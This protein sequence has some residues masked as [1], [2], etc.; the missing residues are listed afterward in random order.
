MQSGSI[1]AT[2]EAIEKVLTENGY[3]IEKTVAEA[4]PELVEPKREDFKSDE[5]FDAAQEQFETKQEEVA[6]AAE[7]KEEH[8]EEA[9]EK[10]ERENGRNKPSR[11]QRA[12]DKATRELKEKN[13]Q[14]E[15]RLAALEGK[16]PVAAG[17]LKIE[18]PKREDF[19]SDQEFDD[20]MFDYRYKVRR[21][22]EETENQQKAQQDR[23][24]ENFE[25]YQTS[26]AAFKEEHDD[27]DEVVDQKI[28]IHESVYLTIM[29]LENGP[30]VTYYLGKHPDFARRIAELSPLSAVVEVGKLAD[31]LANGQKPQDKDEKR[32][33]TRIP[34]KA[35]PEPVKPVST[36][37]SASTL[38]SR[39]AAK[40]RDYK[41]FKAAQRRGA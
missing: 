11:K 10:K 16:K 27:W 35:I 26:V 4:P 8:E 39:E 15:E 19:K 13:Q 40:N 6:A 7:E 17:A 29:E 25:N 31:K 22:K 37:A 1:G 41:A 33:A 5:D 24:K 12:I 14:L 2:P 23:L 9:R 21:A 36:S 28:P 38:T 3:E 20:A 30:Q 32:T 34:P 18:A